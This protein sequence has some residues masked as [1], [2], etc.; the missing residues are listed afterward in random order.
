MSSKF[1]RVHRLEQPKRSKHDA[2]SGLN[3][4]SPKRKENIINM[5]TRAKAVEEHIKKEG[6]K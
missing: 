2:D 1:E 5:R 6:L 3:T 4:V